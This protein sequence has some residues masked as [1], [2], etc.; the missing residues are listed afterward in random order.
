MKK[1]YVF[2][3][4]AVSTASTLLSCEKD[5]PVANNAVQ[6]SSNATAVTG[7]T[8]NYVYTLAGN[9]FYLNQNDGVG[10]KAGFYVLGQMVADDGFLYALDEPLIRKINISDRTVT[11]LAGKEW[12]DSRDGLGP[13]AVFKSPSAIA[14]APDGNLYVSEFSKIRK[15]T[16]EGRV[17]TIAGM[18][19]RGHRDGP[20]KTA[21]FQRPISI[22]VCEDG[23]IYV[24]DDQSQ[25]PG[26][27]FQIRKI[28]REGV[29][30]TLTKGPVGTP[31][32]PWKI[33]SLAV[34]NKTIYAGGDGIFKISSKGTVT[35]VKK[36]ITVKYNSLLPQ[37]D[38]SFLIASDNQIKKVSANG[39]VSVVAGLPVHDIYA[40]PTEGPADSVDLH[41]P[42]GIALYK[43]VLYIAVHPLVG[44]PGSDE[45]QQGSVIQ[46]M[47]LPD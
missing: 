27:D 6:Q 5:V 44:L 22:A 46:M 19:A 21:L 26:T 35:T 31:S 42:S 24:I 41:D 10:D 34:Q 25:W 14:L 43:N 39:T 28:S 38:G 33:E 32:S 4:A 36:D 20:A 23:A 29:V 47:A 45:Y 17:T 8:P 18:D 2:L 12:G 1:M 30:S 7:L 16:K 9:S 3:L 11:T 13:Q 40:A 15:V 37:A